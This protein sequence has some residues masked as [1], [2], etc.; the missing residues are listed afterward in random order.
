MKQF[1]HGMSTAV[2]LSR[3]GDVLPIAPF[4]LSLFPGKHPSI[5]E[6]CQLKCPFCINLHIFSLP[7]PFLPVL[8]TGIQLNQGK[9]MFPL[10]HKPHRSITD[11]CDMPAGGHILGLNHP[12]LKALSLCHSS[13][14]QRQQERP[15]PGI[16]MCSANSQSLFDNSLCCS[17][18]SCKPGLA[19]SLRSSWPCLPATSA[20][21][22]QD[23]STVLVPTQSSLGCWKPR[24]CAP[25]HSP[26][27]EASSPKSASSKSAEVTVRISSLWESAVPNPFLRPW[28]CQRFCVW[29]HPAA[30]CEHWELWPGM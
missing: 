27:S 28:P 11:G 5:E 16:G 1:S 13:H 26:A 23:V 18:S 29:L 6:S 24:P 25:A 4:P 7:H 8:I 22:G 2:Q 15:D 30:G 14:S 19:L 10:T 17:H 9:E 20:I 12:G 3:V 21:T